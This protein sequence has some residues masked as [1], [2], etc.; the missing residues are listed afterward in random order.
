MHRSYVIPPTLS[1]TT[2]FEST[3]MRMPE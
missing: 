2:T 1:K 3:S